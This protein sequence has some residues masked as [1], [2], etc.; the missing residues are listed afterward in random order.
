MEPGQP[1]GEPGW[2]ARTYAYDGTQTSGNYTYQQPHAVT[3][4]TGGTSTDA[5]TYDQNGNMTCR[6]ENGSTYKQVYNAENRLSSV[7]KIAT[8]TCASPTTLSAKWDF[9]GACPE[10]AQRSRRDGDG[11]R[12]TQLYTPYDQNGNPQTPVLTVYFLG[13]AYE[14]TGSAVK[15]Y[16]AIAGMTVA[17][18]DGSGLKYLLTDHLGS[19]VG[20]TDGNGTLISQQ[21]YLP[22][23]QVRSD[24]TPSVTQ[25]DLS[26][27]G[28]RSLSMGL[29]DY[30]AR[31]YEQDLGRFTSPDSIVP[32]PANPQSFNRYAYVN[33]SPIS[34]SD[35]S[36]HK[37]C[38][39]TKKYSC[40]LTAEDV[41]SSYEAA[42]TEDKPAVAEFFRS[43]GW[44][45]GNGIE[46]DTDGD[47]IPDIPDPSIKVTLGSNVNPEGFNCV[48]TYV[49]CF[50][51][52]NVLELDGDVQ[53]DKGQFGLLL[54]AI[55]FDVKNR[56]PYSGYDHSIRD[57]YDTPFYNGGGAGSTLSPLG[58]RAC[59]DNNCY[60]R[61]AV[62]YVGQGM[63]VA[64]AGQSL[65]EGE[66]GVLAWK[67]TKYG[68]GVDSDTLYWFKVG[69]EAY[70]SLDQ[71]YESLSA[72]YK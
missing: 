52:R 50:Y 42:K 29:M 25:T 5:Y 14:V 31:M 15:K 53:I 62:N 60:D 44:Q 64:G 10:R 69:Y 28:Q 8:G 20:V 26:Y 41:K 17:M 16:Y 32:N 51:L 66:L 47:G 22:F 59:W 54:L 70:K 71:N 37:P 40:N 21:R 72:T 55:Y 3:S 19:V 34:F 46:H 63:L 2:E 56:Q 7:Q 61:S 57:V 11:V 23:G 36:G 30:H 48:E 24:V 49:E 58:G 9:A 27:T 6:A 65:L 43:Q 39:A 18:N 13:G 1:A 67:I 68:T 45:V 35:P 33:N 12:V 38:W 4:V